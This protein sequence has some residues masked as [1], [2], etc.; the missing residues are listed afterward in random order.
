M[1][2][3]ERLL[4]LGGASERSAYEDWDMWMSVAQ[5]GG[6]GVVIDVP[7]FRYRIHRTSVRRC[8]VAKDRFP[9]EYAAMVRGHQPLFERRAEL[10]RASTLRPMQ[11]L[12]E[13]A[14]LAVKRRLPRHARRLIYGTAAWIETRRSVTQAT[15]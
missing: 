15:T 8:A 4:E 1:V 9:T 5:A 2:R 3:R 13:R 14:M 12:R 6:H 7:M 11:R 10:A